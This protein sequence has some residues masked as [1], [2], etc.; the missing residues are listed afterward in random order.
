M[1]RSEVRYDLPSDT[2]TSVLREDG[3]E[4]GLIGKLQGLKYDYR[5]DIT[6]RATLEKNFRE[7]FEAL[8]RV[9]LTDSEFAR[10]LDEIVAPD[11]FIASK[12]LRSINSCTISRYMALNSLN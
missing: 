12:T 6:N 5:R 1:P 10:L 7:K 2:P 3:I 4:S 11:V 9:R 8:N